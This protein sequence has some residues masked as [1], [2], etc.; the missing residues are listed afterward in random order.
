MDTVRSSQT[1]K[2]IGKDN[3]SRDVSCSTLDGTPSFSNESRPE[4]SLF[5]SAPIYPEPA[6][7]CVR[8]QPKNEVVVFCN[9][10]VVVRG[11]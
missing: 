10:V 9:F 7:R 3:T 5:T 1:N 2:S 11:K 6:V 4:Y 8:T